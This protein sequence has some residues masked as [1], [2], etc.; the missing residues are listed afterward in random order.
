MAGTREID[1]RTSCKLWRSTGMAGEGRL[2]REQPGRLFDRAR[3]EIPTTTDIYSTLHPNS[4]LARARRWGLVI[5]E[6]KETME[7]KSTSEI[8]SVCPGG[9]IVGNT[10]S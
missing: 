5:E 8:V 10:M 3:G 2:E 1:Q 9:D 4:K 7:K 6:N